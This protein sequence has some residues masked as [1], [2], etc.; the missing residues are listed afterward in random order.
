[1]VGIWETELSSWPQEEQNLLS[2][3]FSAEHFGHWII[4]FT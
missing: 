2:S 3:E 4:T 1:M